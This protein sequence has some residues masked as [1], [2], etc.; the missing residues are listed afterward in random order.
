MKTAPASDEP[1]PERCHRAVLLDAVAVWHDDRRVEPQPRRG[2]RDALPVIAGGRGHHAAN[3]RL[4]PPDLVE[5]DE[6]AADLEGADRR[7]VLVLHPQLGAE[8][9][10]Q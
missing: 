6:A 1:R 3:P 7:M 5:I 10:R 4:R 8:A 2:E 9:A